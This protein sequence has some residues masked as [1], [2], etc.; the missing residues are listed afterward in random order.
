MDQAVASIR[1]ANPHA[2]IEA[3]GGITLNNVRQV[4]GT[5][6]NLISVG[7]LTHSAPAFD[8]SLLLRD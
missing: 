8:Y 5:G 2:E 4:A 7:T 6:V 3:T 1:R